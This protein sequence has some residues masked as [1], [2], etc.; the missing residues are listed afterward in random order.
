MCPYP[1]AAE[2]GARGLFEGNSATACRYPHSAFRWRTG[3][4]AVADPG[5]MRF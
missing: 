2:F 5:F 1:I 3:G 4:V